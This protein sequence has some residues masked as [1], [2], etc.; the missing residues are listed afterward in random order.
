MEE[1]AV[2]Y[3]S[4][5]GAQKF[6]VLNRPSP[7]RLS[8]VGDFNQGPYSCCMHQSSGVIKFHLKFARDLLSSALQRK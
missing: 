2:V 6:N 4:N 1:P 8:H 5:C 3:G 7:A